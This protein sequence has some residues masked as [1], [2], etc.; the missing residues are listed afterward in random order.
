M[1]F[2]EILAL[3]KSIVSGRK[4][5][6]VGVLLLI[7]VIGAYPSDLPSYRDD[8]Y[9]PHEDMLV[10][11]VE[12]YA[13]HVNT[14]V[15]LAVPVLL[16]DWTGLKQLGVVT[17]AGILATHVPKRLLNDVWAGDTRLGQ[18][19]HAPDSRHNMPSG[20]SALASAAIWFLGRRYSWWWALM[21]VPITLLTMYA[22]V[23]LDA[24]TVSAVIVGCL[25]GMLVAALF[26]T[27]RSRQD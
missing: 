22:R 17:V 2:R 18:R 8:A 21:T 13:R 7:L 1:T 12:D 20:H 4:L 16:R 23:M 10:V 15:A 14:V 25:V 24:H 6:V 11:G 19:P 9:D 3:P 5:T 26:V 27:R